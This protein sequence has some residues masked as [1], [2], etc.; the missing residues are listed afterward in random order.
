MKNATMKKNIFTIIIFG[1]ATILS[2]KTSTIYSDSLV[3]KG[4]DA[5]DTLNIISNDSL[6]SKDSVSNKTKEKSFKFIKSI[7]TTENQPYFEPITK[8]KFETEDYRNLSDIF[9]YQPFGF[10][11]DLGSLGQPNEQMFYGLGFGSISYLNDGVLLNNRWQNAYDLNRINTE[12]IDSIH[13]APLTKGFLYSSYN[14]PISIMINSR[15]EY[16][17]NAITKM[18][19]YQ[20]SYDEGFV[21]VQFHAPINNKSSFGIGI[22]NSAVDSRFANSDYESWKF[23]THFNYQIN[24]QFNLNI[25]YQYSYDTLALFGGLDTNKMLNDNYSTVLYDNETSNQSKRYQLNYNNNGYVKLLAEIIPNLKSDF[26]IFMNTYSQKYFQNKDGISDN[27]NTIVHGNYHQTIGASLRNM[28][29][30]PFITIDI[31][32]NYE[33]NLFNTDLFKDNSNQLIYS[34]SGEIKLFAREKYF[35]PTVFGKTSNF[36][37]KSLHGFGFDFSGSINNQLSYYAGVSLFQK[38]VTILEDGYSTYPSLFPSL[39]VSYPLDISEHKTLEVGVKYNSS[40]ISVKIT[41]F[42]YEANNQAF[43]L[44]IQKQNDSLLVNELSY[45]STKNISNSGI[46]LNFNFMVWKVLF[47]NNIS[48]YFSERAERG[49]AS[50][51]YTIAGKIYYL[52]RL[53]ENNLNLKTGINYRFTG[54]QSPFVYDYEKSLQITSELSSLVYYDN[55]PASFQLDLFLA[56]TIQERA[57]VFVTLENVLNSEYYIVPYY[58][59]QPITLRFGV[60]WLLFD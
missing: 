41:Y 37:G 39:T 29:E 19:F 11:Q 56:G 59:K 46:N 6:I 42:T 20:A 8:S 18:K 34:L 28:F 1:L 36:D 60:S 50:P 53:F 16:P 58:I 24:E 7:G 5:L 13:I 48:Y 32:G 4:F 26:T 2:A 3:N 38:Q 23:N 25:V 30:L 40:I 17:T 14:N 49:Y 44:I 27:L 12:F 45:Y 57:T 52:D 55:V 15:F 22:S 43:P 54:G 10:N 51:D 33:K 21:N 47:S 31:I 35:V 9:T